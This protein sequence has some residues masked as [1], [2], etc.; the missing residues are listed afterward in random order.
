VDV[1]D[2]HLEPVERARL[3]QLHLAHEAGTQVF[4]DDAVRRG[5]KRQ[6]VRDK[7]LLV[8]RQ[9]VPVTEVIAQVDLLGCC[10]VGGIFF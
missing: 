3:R 2:R 9:L 7:V 4:V 6:D 5:E 8:R 1:L 10:L